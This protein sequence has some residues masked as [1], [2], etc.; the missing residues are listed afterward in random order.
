MAY[1]RRQWPDRG[2]VQPPAD[3]EA[4]ARDICLRQL[5]LSPKTR[6]QL[7][8]ALARKAIPDEV[9]EQ[10]LGR[11][12]EVGLI[13]DE[14]FA[15]A[16]VRS[17]HNGKG[18]APRA[19]SA[20]LRRKGVDEETVKEAVA[21]LQPEDLDAAARA[22]VARK[23]ASTAGL[24]PAKRTRRLVGML[25]RKGYAPGLAYQVVRDA[26]AESSSDDDFDSPPP[27][28]PL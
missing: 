28:A 2:E 16:W 8:E 9:A 6:A 18:L 7:A 11:F 5:T 17:R 23:L 24:D 27:D 3:P 22:L 13:D 20:E 25:A 4:A 10:V 12:T 14:A 21:D 26:L 19:L 1:R 15:Q